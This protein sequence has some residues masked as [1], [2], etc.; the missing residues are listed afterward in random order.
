MEK[1]EENRRMID[2]LRIYE[3]FEENKAALRAG[4]R[5]HAARIMTRHGFRIPRATD[6]PDAFE[7]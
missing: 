6:C 1:S 5:G 2:Q 4:F 7:P 3:I